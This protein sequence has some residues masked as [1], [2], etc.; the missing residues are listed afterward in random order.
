[1][2]HELY[3]RVSAKVRSTFTSTIRNFVFFENDTGDVIEARLQR[4]EREI[5]R[6]N[7]QIYTQPTD[8]KSRL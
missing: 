3:T 7:A 8:R 4:I 2:L 5:V 1:M 6:I